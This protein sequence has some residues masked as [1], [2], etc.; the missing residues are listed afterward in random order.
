[1][2]QCLGVLRATSSDSHPQ[3]PRCHDAAAACLR[4]AWTAAAVSVSDLQLPANCRQTSCAITSAGCRESGGGCWPASGSMPTTPRLWRLSWLSLWARRQRLG[5]L[6]RLARQTGGHCD[7]ADV[8]CL[9]CEVL[10][11]WQRQGGQDK[12]ESAYWWR[13][14]CCRRHIQMQTEPGLAEESASRQVLDCPPC[15]QSPPAA[16]WGADACGGRPW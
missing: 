3:G 14:R 9:S 16:A 6:P 1:M 8:G 4:L 5:G 13:P 2:H 10:T 12:A 15:L 7:C 11:A